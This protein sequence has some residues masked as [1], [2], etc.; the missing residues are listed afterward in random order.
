MK[1]IL[2][3]LYI[4]I[5]LPTFVFAD[6]LILNECEYS[7]AYIKY[8]S[9]DEDEKKL[10]DE[11]IK[12]KLSNPVSYFRL[13]SLNYGDRLINSSSY[14]LKDHSQDSVVE[15]QM[16]TG[17]CWAFS[18]ND[19]IETYLLKYELG[20][21]NLSERHMEYSTVR[22]FL[23]FAQAASS[24]FSGK[25]HNV[26]GRKRPALIPCSRRTFTAFLQTRAEVP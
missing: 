8:L 17:T 26:I 13:P 9:L 22:T 7:E 5:F 14:F 15:N 12:C 11:P 24:S 20:S 23:A 18:A 4:L 3:F 1:K 21:I 2:F 25:G 19:S 16:D 6:S 10:Y